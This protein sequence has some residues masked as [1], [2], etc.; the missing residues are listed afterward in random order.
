MSDMISAFE[1]IIATAANITTIIKAVYPDKSK[2]RLDDLEKEI[3]KLGNEFVKEKILNDD[4]YNLFVQIMQNTMLNGTKE[5][6]KRFAKIA[7]AV[8]YIEFMEIPRGERYVYIVNALSDQ[9]MAVFILL[10]KELETE[11][12]KINEI[13]VPTTR[14]DYDDNIKEIFLRLGIPKVEWSFTIKKLESVGLLQ[15]E[16]MTAGSGIRYR[17]SDIGKCFVDFLEMQE[18]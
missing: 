3:S 6:I 5:K 8:Y 9:E 16:N 4:E 11:T 14:A 13:R 15:F 10:Y 12:G 2:Q 1:A 7:H 18:N 17:I